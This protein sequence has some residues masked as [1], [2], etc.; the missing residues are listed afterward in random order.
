[1]PRGRGEASE[2][3]AVGVS[4]LEVRAQSRL[5]NAVLCR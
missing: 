1:V 5:H 2:I 4:H 3:V